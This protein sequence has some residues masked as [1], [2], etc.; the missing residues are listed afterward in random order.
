M[1][2]LTYIIGPPSNQATTITPSSTLE[3]EELALSKDLV[4]QFTWHLC[5]TASCAVIVVLLYLN[6]SQ[7]VIGTEIGKTAQATSSILGALQL[8]AKVH[9]ILM[10]SSLVNIGQQYMQRCLI[11]DGTLLGL[12]GA[13]V[14]LASLALLVSR[15]FRA[16]IN[17]TIAL[18]R[19]RWEG[20]CTED[21][22]R[23]GRKLFQ[24]I[25]FIF[26]ACLL[27]ALAG[28]ASAVLM[29]PRYEWFHEVDID[30]FNPEY[31][32]DKIPQCYG[33]ILI[34]TALGEARDKIYPYHVDFN[35]R[36][37]YWITA[38]KGNALYIHA[39]GDLIQES[40]RFNDKV[41]NT[42]TRWNRPLAAGA[43]WMGSTKLSG[44][45][46]S[47]VTQES[48]RLI[49]YNVSHKNYGSRAAFVGD[50]TGV[51]VDIVCRRRRKEPCN[52]SINSVGNGSEWCYMAV[53]QDSLEGQ[54]QSNQDLLLV[55]DFD[56]YNYAAQPS[57]LWM[58]EG[59]RAAV[60][61]KF[62]ETIVFVFE[63]N[64]S[65]DYYPDIPDPSLIVCSVSAVLKAAT[66]SSPDQL[67][68]PEQAHFHDHLPY[69]GGS[70]RK[71]LYHENWL[72]V[73]HIK[74]FYKVNSTIIVL[75]ANT[76]YPS[77]GAQSKPTENLRF[78]DWASILTSVVGPYEN[79][80]ILRGGLAEVTEAAL[81]ELIVGGSYI[82]VLL[83]MQTSHSQ[84]PAIYGIGG[85]IEGQMY[86]EDLMP[87]PLLNC[88]MYALPPVKVYRQVYGFQL[89]SH[90]GVLCAA[91]LIT[92]VVVALL[93]SLWQCC[94]GG[95]IE[96]WRSIPEY[97]V[98]ALRSESIGKEVGSMA[99]RIDKDETLKKIVRV[100]PVT[101]EHLELVVSSPEKTLLG[102]RERR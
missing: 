79:R 18:L 55:V 35:D 1:E 77:R 49:D 102:I 21:E 7:Y 37:D 65:G 8:A 94:Q 72:D 98:L 52:H 5:T 34:D 51:E 47:D 84:Y 64:D 53:I 2:T 60:N 99:L 48:G 16:A 14:S 93:G 13:E 30:G 71:F 97:V 26:L 75:E 25:G 76:T 44:V 58:A 73:I 43:N 70:P 23:L 74:N 29:V 45:M 20:R 63:E 42:T 24:L 6:F 19:Q 85:Q 67:F 82:D 12:V 86:P 11:G 36:V 40:H 10:V 101:E 46:G 87:E 59:P 80:E 33:N 32:G 4:S 91:I 38:L 9:E 50:L 92:Y 88:T 89:S 61:K 15:E 78:R 57:R 62:T 41:V 39:Q 66:V 100:R 68:S 69:F 83:D 31:V 96:A 56:P 28:P 95:V 27:C 81:I 90:I 17:F 54:L 22:W 3:A